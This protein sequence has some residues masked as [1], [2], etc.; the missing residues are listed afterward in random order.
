MEGRKEAISDYFEQLPGQT[1][2]NYDLN[3]QNSQPPDHKLK[4]GPPKYKARLSVN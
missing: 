1:E 4:L 3:S 2:E